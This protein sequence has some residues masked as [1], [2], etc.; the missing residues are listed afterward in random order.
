MEHPTMCDLANLEKIDPTL[1]GQSLNAQNRTQ[2]G[3]IR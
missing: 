3:G 2:V 1:L